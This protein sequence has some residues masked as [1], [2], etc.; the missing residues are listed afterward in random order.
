[1]MMMLLLVVGFQGFL[2]ISVLLYHNF[3]F[4]LGKL[5]AKVEKGAPQA[6]SF[7]PLNGDLEK[8]PLAN[9]VTLEIP[10]RPCV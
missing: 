3:Y 8:R 10:S 9:M 5:W 1:M 4:D 7:K 6:H 2:R